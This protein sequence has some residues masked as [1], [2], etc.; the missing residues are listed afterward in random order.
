MTKLIKN[1][2]CTKRMRAHQARF[3]RPGG[4]S[5]V[6][7]VQARDADGPMDRKGVEQS[8]SLSSREGIRGIQMSTQ[9]PR[10]AGFY[11]PL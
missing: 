3:V 7:A 8:L 1:Y 10:V 4:R 2:T 11:S 9:S 6:T 5:S